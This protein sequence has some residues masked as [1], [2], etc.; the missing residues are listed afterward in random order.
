M[1][2]IEF[3]FKTFVLV[4]AYLISAIQFFRR[5]PLHDSEVRDTIAFLRGLP[6]SE[7]GGNFT[8]YQVTDGTSFVKA[9]LQS[10]VRETK[11]VSCDVLEDGRAA[12]AILWISGLI[13]NEYV[14]RN[15]VQFVN[16]TTDMRDL[17]SACR[18][19]MY[20]EDSAEERRAK[21]NSII[22][23]NQ[24]STDVT[25]GRTMINDTHFNTNTSDQTAAGKSGSQPG[26]VKT[27]L[28][29]IYPGTLWCGVNNIAGDI[30]SKL[31]PQREAD[32]CCRA[33]DHCRPNVKSF[34]HRYHMTN[35]SLWL[36]S[37]CSCDRTFYN[38]MKRARTQTADEVGRLFF[39]GLNMKCFDFDFKETCVLSLFGMCLDTEYLCAAVIKDNKRY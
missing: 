5:Y 21:S 17:L 35:P 1:P 28:N 10:D 18:Y 38:C 20:L 26:S 32:K 14:N 15:I 29:G 23:I 33:H 8:I 30:Y 24:R 9:V 16:Q 3:S 27:L 25:G 36:M 34:E 13:R 12:D 4:L 31:G 7:C 39:N 11:L 19:I 6:G 37:H 2:V 22:G